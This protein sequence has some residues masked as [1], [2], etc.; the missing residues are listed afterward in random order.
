MQLN[1]GNFEAKVHTHSE[2]L[3][4]SKTTITKHPMMCGGLWLHLTG[5]AVYQHIN[6]MLLSL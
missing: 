4:G 2:R 1:M 5:T 3:H 6:L